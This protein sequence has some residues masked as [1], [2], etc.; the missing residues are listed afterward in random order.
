MQLRNRAAPLGETFWERGRDVVHY[1]DGKARDDLEV[2]FVV[3][4][5]RAPGKPRRTLVEG[6]EL[7][8]RKDRRIS[9]D[10]E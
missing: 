2:H 8:A 3:T 6:D 1:Q 7:V 4:M 9:A 5:L 10:A